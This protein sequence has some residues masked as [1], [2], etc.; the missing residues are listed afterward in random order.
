MRLSIAI[1]VVIL[2]FV[3]AEGTTP[4]CKN[5]P[6]EMMLLPGVCEK[7]SYTC[8]CDCSLGCSYNQKVV[9]KGATL[10]N[11]GIETL[12]D[13]MD[14]CETC[15]GFWN[16]WK[17]AV[18]NPSYKQSTVVLDICTVSKDYDV[19]VNDCVI[20]QTSPS[21]SPSPSPSMSPSLPTEQQVLTFLQVDALFELLAGSKGFIPQYLWTW[22]KYDQVIA[23]N[24]TYL[25]EV[26]NKL[27]DSWREFKNVGGH[28]AIQVCK[29]VYPK[30]LTNAPFGLES[31]SVV[32]G[33]IVYLK[34]NI[35]E[36]FALVQYVANLVNIPVSLPSSP[37]MTPSS[38]SASPK[39]QSSP[40]VPTVVVRSPGASP[41]LQP[42]P[43][44]TSNFND[45]N[46]DLSDA[47]SA[48]ALAWWIITLI[49]VGCVVVLV[50]LACLLC[51]LCGRCM[52]K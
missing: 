43:S 48:L 14:V 38:P 52:A 26:R 25:D 21:P 29:L 10:Q 39:L 40:S 32:E 16:A 36:Y 49:V 28:G 41:K 18:N 6:I 27:Y 46:I 2:S 31:W 33:S 4:Y 37:T 51:C 20:A 1:Q 24:T 11:V 3:C 42:S 44:P 15:F 9:S 22:V 23:K 50:V 7:V 17:C 47:G 30:S 45:T 13:V 12:N 5:C 8:V 34:I 35:D 19:H